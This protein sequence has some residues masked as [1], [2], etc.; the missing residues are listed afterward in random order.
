MQATFQVGI[1]KAVLSDGRKIRHLGLYFVTYF[2][3]V[4]HL[5]LFLNYRIVV[6]HF[7]SDVVHVIDHCAGVIMYSCMEYIG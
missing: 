6:I 5:L 1:F 3:M 4:L 2:E 7:P